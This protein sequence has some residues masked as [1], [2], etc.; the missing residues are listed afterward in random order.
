MTIVARSSVVLAARLVDIGVVL[1]AAG[2]TDLAARVANLAAKS[3]VVV[4]V[5]GLVDL[6]TRLTGARK[7]DIVV[8]D[9]A[10]SVDVAAG[11]LKFVVK[12]IKI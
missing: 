6:A 12:L 9:R 7:T 2:K 8:A 3:C 11:V 4:V 5:A 1:A 10:V